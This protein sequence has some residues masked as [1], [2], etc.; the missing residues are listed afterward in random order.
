MS[1]ADAVSAD[2]LPSFL[3]DGGDMGRAM[4][5]HDW[6]ASPLGHPAQWPQALKT[7]ASILLSSKFP[8]FLAWGPE[9]TFLYNDGYAEILGAK[10]PAL[11]MP[12]QEIWAEIWPDI[13]PIIDRALAGEATFWENLPLTMNRRGHDELAYFTFSYSPLRAEDGSVRGMFCACTETTA[14]VRK[15]QRRMQQMERLR[16]LLDGAP[17]FMAVVGRDER[18]YLANRA[19]L[20]SIGEEDVVGRLMEEV[21]PPALYPGS[22]KRVR[23]VL[24]T[25]QAYRAEA[26]PVT[27]KGRN[28]APDKELVLDYN[29][30]PIVEHE[31]VIAVFVAGND[32]TA[33][34][35]AEH[36]LR[37]SEARFRTIANSAPVPIWVSNPDRTRDFVNQAYVEF[38]GLPEEEAAK[39]DWRTI[40]HPDDH[41]RIVEAS[42]AGEASL[43]PFT[44]EARYRSG[45]GEWRWIRSTSQPRRDA[46]GAGHSGFIGVA[47]D[48]TDAKEAEAAL[49]ELNET[50]ERRVEERTADLQAALERLQQ[51]VSERERAEEALRQAQKM[52]AVG[53]LTGGIAHDFNNLLTPVIGGLELI[54]R[55][56]ED[57]RLKRMAQA[58][59]ESAQRGAKLATQLLAFSRLQRLTMAPVPVNDVI[60]EMGS[61]LHH[62]I[63]PRIEIVN[64]LGAGVG[65]A[66]CDANQLENAILNLAINGRDAMPD[67]GRL[68]ISTALHEEPQGPDLAAGTYVCLTVEDNGQGMPPEV[69]ARATEPFFSTKPVGKGTGLGLAQVYGIAQQS[70]GT[71]RIHSIEGVGTKV[72]LL[73][74][75]VAGAELAVGGAGE[76]SQAVRRPSGRATILVVDDDPD[77]RSFL[78]HA[79]VELGHEVIACDCAEAGLEQMARGQPDLALIDFAMPGMNGAQLALAAKQ[80]YPAMRIAFVT[81]YAESEQLDA[82]LGGNAAVLRKPFSMDQL[83]DLIGSQLEAAPA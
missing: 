47:H 17:S 40:L 8:M 53:Q 14:A 26:V 50:L 60:V 68:T 61:M 3:L 52:E 2:A 54:A 42:M 55:R 81:G 64:E 63:G 79:L 13:A 5:A 29:V 76:T 33:R 19:Y 75:H 20:A 80:L 45:K 39:L 36:R 25:G 11:G 83:A 65:H 32:V 6:G 46:E 31:E 78:T 28:G 24:K 18:F 37:E 15:E 7:A 71:A 4:R 67:G 72:H 10:H 44:L 30:E 70:G 56:M 82:A 1:D 27:L 51:E 35:A 43:Q 9:L 59:L 16:V 23:E 38:L 69:L 48:V 77:V 41:D 74:P 49:R 22:A 21:F 34:H 62:S 57:E 66:L 58:A 73:L 12:F